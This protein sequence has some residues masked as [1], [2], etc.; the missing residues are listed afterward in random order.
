MPA[1]A[2]QDFVARESGRYL[3]NY[4][5]ERTF[6]ISPWMSLIKRDVFPTGMGET[7]N[8]LTYERMAPTEATPQ[9]QAVTV[10]DGAEGGACLQPAV[11]IPV[12]NTTRNFGLQR[13]ILEGPDFCA[14]E[15]LSPFALRNQLNAIS[16]ILTE[17]SKIQWEQFDRYQY[18]LGVKHKV[19]V[20]AM[21]PTSTSTQATTYPAVAALN[22]LTQG[23]LD[24]WRMILIR[25]GAAGSAMGLENGAPVLSL[26]TTPENSNNII[27]S[28]PDIRQDFRW[29]DPSMLLKAL[30]V[31]RSYRGWYHIVD[32]YAR[33]FSYATGTYTPISP[34]FQSAATKGQK[35]EIN[36]S[37]TTAVY[38]ESFAFDPEVFYQ[39]V[40]PPIVNPAPNF[41]FDPVSYVGEWQ[42]K[43]ILDR[44]K[45]P[46]GTIIYHRGIM[47]A[48]SMPGKPERGVAFVHRNC[49]VASGLSF[50]CAS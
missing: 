30:G 16:E 39:L 11:K 6:G 36:P 38:A 9:W 10:T 29:A 14:V 5:F 13:I 2:V 42:V 7:L 50:Q 35:V 40:P 43:N 12:G 46:D 21:P 8:V 44:I 17:Y 49:P 41:Q 28:N 1:E 4:I 25:D 31:G 33:R 34:Y 18:F 23:I 26:I 19:V 45:N 15:L 20:D 22:E 3:Q 32:L 47:M 27:M 48:G 37:W 24:Y